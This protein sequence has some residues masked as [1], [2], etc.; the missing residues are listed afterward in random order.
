[1]DH[2][3]L[4]LS[5]PGSQISVIKSLAIDKLSLFN[6][7][8]GP[9]SSG[10]S[11]A[12]EYIN[13][14]CHKSIK[15]SSFDNS[16]IDNILSRPL[17]YIPPIDVLN[18]I[19]LLVKTIDPRILGIKIYSNRFIINKPHN[20]RFSK[21]L[22]KS[23]III[24]SMLNNSDHI[25]LIDELDNSFHYSIYGILIDVLYSLSTLNNLQVCFTSHS[26]EFI[27]CFIYKDYLKSDN[28]LSLFRF[29]RDNEAKIEHMDISTLVRLRDLGQDI[30]G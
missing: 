11:A 26:I 22:N 15:I 29:I 19:N 25:L 9:N 24:L 3:S 7:F 10:K 14:K 23:I 12:L 16:S 27:D 4:P 5:N 21:G 6:I 28:N 18:K 17:I 13:S 1:M 2:S 20:Y 30:R 8:V